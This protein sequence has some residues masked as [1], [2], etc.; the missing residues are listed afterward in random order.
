MK[1][2]KSCNFCDSR[3][4]RVL[5]Y[6]R[7]KNFDVPGKFPILK[8]K[9]CGLI[10][11]GI[12]INQ[13]KLEEYYPKE[14]Y[15]FNKIDPNS[16]KLRVKMLLYNLYFNPKNKNK[17]FSLIFLPLLPF[18]RGII[19][20]PNKKLLDI[21]S[22]SGQFLY[23]MKG[24]GMKEYGIEPGNFDKESAKKYGLNIKKTDLIKEK[25]P[26]EYFDI[27]TINHVL[28]HVS[29]PTK[30]IREIHKILKENGWL[31]IGVPNYRSLAYLLFRKN[32]YQLDIPRHLYDFSDKTLVR[33][34]EKEGFRVDKIRYNSRPAQ[35]VISIFYS[36]NIN[37]KK[38]PILAN[39]LSILFLP[40]AYAVNAIKFGDQ[41]EIY[42]SK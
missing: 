14:Y 2:I 4:F 16:L 10:F 3:N 20:S 17:L 38:H 11:I 31:I 41:I 1:T 24:F 27:I 25:Y 42:C 29:N 32:W 15:S 18:S 40:L 8:C 21:G 37:H 19:I 5:F 26:N 36:L 30:I 34:L 13:K 9:K 39:I 22:G 33:K 35:F 7:D 12:R 6:G 23:E 28:E